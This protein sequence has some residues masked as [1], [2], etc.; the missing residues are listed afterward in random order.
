MVFVLWRLVW[1]MQCPFMRGLCPFSLRKKNSRQK[2]GG[3][4]RA[5]ELKIRVWGVR[6]LGQLIKTSQIVGGG[7][8]IWELAVPLNC[9]A[10]RNLFSR[11]E[12][13][14][15]VFFHLPREIC[16]FFF[17][18]HPPPRQVFRLSPLCLSAFLQ[19][20]STI[21][22]R[23]IA[24]DSWYLLFCIKA[25]PLFEGHHRVPSLSPKRSNQ[26]LSPPPPSSPCRINTKSMHQ[27]QRQS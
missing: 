16:E 18:P 20:W 27:S 15:G 21:P 12:K 17:C 14:L 23:S 9:N 7:S 8:T 10:V 26:A 11:R 1:W 2:G 25:Q 6:Y 3:G 5:A 22:G 24:L 4:Y 19:S 13:I